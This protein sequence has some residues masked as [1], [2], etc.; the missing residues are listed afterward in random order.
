ML[1]AIAKNANPSGAAGFLAADAG[2][3]DCM[4]IGVFNAMAMFPPA[5][6]IPLVSPFAGVYAAIEEK[7]VVLGNP[8]PNTSPKEVCT[9]WGAERGAI[10]RAGA[11]A[12]AGPAAGAGEGA[13]ALVPAPA[14]AA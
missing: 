5:P 2:R 14:A 10:A 12:T 6:S 7:G 3:A 9:N 4:D 1:A 13:A 11:V 8:A